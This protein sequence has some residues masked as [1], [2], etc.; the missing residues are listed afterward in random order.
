MCT[1]YIHL[2]Q[3]RVKRVEKT[4]DSCLPTKVKWRRQVCFFICGVFKTK[5]SPYAHISG[6]A[7]KYP[8]AYREHR[9]FLLVVVVDTLQYPGFLCI[10]D[11]APMPPQQADPKLLEALAR[12]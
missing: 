10:L 3:F 6:G 1:Q 8:L 9:Y 7:L 12:G 2:L 11:S 5:Q 4:L